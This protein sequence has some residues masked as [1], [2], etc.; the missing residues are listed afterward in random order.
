MSDQ[1]TNQQKTLINTIITLFKFFKKDFND[2][3]EKLDSFI[4][5]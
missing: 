1:N 5:V 2:E 4:F 3:I